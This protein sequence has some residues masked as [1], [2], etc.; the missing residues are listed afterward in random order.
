M[1]DPEKF[2]RQLELEEEML[3]VGRMN[4]LRHESKAAEAGKL[5]QTAGGE[6]YVA[7]ALGH[8]ESYLEAWLKGQS[9]RRG[10]TVSIVYKPLK[11]VGAAKAAVLGLRCVLDSLAVDER[12]YTR[13]ALRVG[14][15]VNQEARFQAFKREQP[16]LLNSIIKRL[17][18]ANTSSESHRQK[19]VMGNMRR[20]G[21]EEGSLWSSN[22]RVTIGGL[23]IDAIEQ[24]TDLIEVVNV[25]RGKK[26]KT[27]VEITEV[28]LDAIEKT[29]EIKSLLCPA[30]LPCIVL[31]REWEGPWGGGYHSKAVGDH[32]LVKTRNR[33]YL[34]DLSHIPMPAVYD[35]LNTLQSTALRVNEFIL[36]TYKEVVKLAGAPA[37]LPPRDNVPMPPKPHDI[38]ENEEARNEYRVAARKV[39]E[40]NRQIMSKRLLFM[41]V[42]GI[43]DKFRGEEE[44]FFPYQLD[45]RGRIY[46]M[47][48]GLTPQGS[49][50]SKAL[51]EFARPKPI[52][53]PDGAAALFVHTANC[54]GVDKVSLDER[55]QWVK[56]NM[57][58]IEACVIDPIENTWWMEADGGDHAWSF[59]RACADVVG[60]MTDGY[61][62][63]SHLPVY[64]DAT[65][66][67]LQHFSAMVRDRRGAEATNLIPSETPRDIYAD[68]AEAAL[69]LVEKDAVKDWK[70]NIPSFPELKGVK[71]DDVSRKVGAWKDMAS[72]YLAA[73]WLKYGIDR[74]LVKR[75][76]MTLPYGATKFSHRQFL[77]DHV[78]DTAVKGG[79]I[80]FEDFEREACSYLAE[81]VWTAIHTVV[82][83]APRVMG[84]LRDCAKV[85]SSENLPIGWVTPSGFPVL[86][87]YRKQTK[88]RV[89]LTLGN[90][91]RRV[92]LNK[93]TEAIDGHRQANG[94]VPNF[95]HSNDAANLVLTV[96][97]AREV[98]VED[99]LTNH[100]AFACHAANAALLGDAHRDTFVAMYEKHDVMQELHDQLQG[101]MV[102][103]TKGIPEPPKK[104]DL[105]LT[106][107]R[108]SLYFAS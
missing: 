67:G 74:K 17:N 1:I 9:R 92:T 97:A 75:C 11:E 19:V 55:V 62:F 100:D 31:P 105:E 26:T 63:E 38:K 79:E 47:P 83:A 96:N 54:Y 87:A 71:K 21:E 14:T 18:R 6:T 52:T 59:L 84:W 33:T 29:E 35:A 68:V 95:V 16:R 20:R 85:A 57:D 78:Q 58:N 24:S 102:D 39:I 101:G 66:S 36:D 104:G 34:S 82:Q 3:E 70:G 76:V 86:Q 15:L 43:A 77:Y 10:S 98:G 49:D 99:I 107:V 94:L 53:D 93:D 51:L 65:C 4:F 37:G 91:Q 5:S 88:S 45:F 40:E 72:P 25:R 2:K 7:V 73:A 108:E 32:S 48:H 23:V 22:V 60:L 27:T 46:T 69:K 103:Q 81:H 106:Q 13:L 61:G 42:E 44:L 30:L 50:F 90:H 12:T 64:M 80:P 89:K 8:V 56:D 28:A 41:Q